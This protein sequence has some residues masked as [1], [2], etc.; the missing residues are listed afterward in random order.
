[1][2]AAQKAGLP[3]GER[4]LIDN[5]TYMNSVVVARMIQHLQNSN[6]IGITV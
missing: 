1:M 3:S 5:F 4:F 6:V 2:E